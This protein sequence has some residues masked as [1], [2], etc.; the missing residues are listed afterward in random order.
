MAGN[1]S[2]A[3]TRESNPDP[4]CRSHPWY[5]L[6]HPYPYQYVVAIVTTDLIIARII[7]F[8]LDNYIIFASHYIRLL[9]D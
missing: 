6:E 2:P 8:H 4:L 3:D 5:P 9:N 1:G 7:Q